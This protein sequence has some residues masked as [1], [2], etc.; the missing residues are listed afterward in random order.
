MRRG[1][2]AAQRAAVERGAGGLRARARRPG[3]PALRDAARELL[4]Y[5]ERRTKSALS[6][7]PSA[8]MTATDYLEGDGVIDDD[9]EIRVSVAI[10]DGVF[11]ADFTGT[12]DAAPGNVNCPIAVTRSEERRVGKECRSRWSPYH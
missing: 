10:E 4:D 1:D 7:L 5:A 9:L 12:R 11:Y 3:W 2:L 8:R 6:R